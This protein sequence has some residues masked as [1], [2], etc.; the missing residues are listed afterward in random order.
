MNNFKLVSEIPMEFIEHSIQQGIDIANKKKFLTDGDLQRIYFAGATLFLDT[1]DEF[2]FSDVITI[3]HS[4][5]CYGYFSGKCIRHLLSIKAC[6]KL[7]E[8]MKICNIKHKK[9]WINY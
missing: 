7:E 9:K 5:E 4:S 3:C 2:G 6:K 8:L 1:Q